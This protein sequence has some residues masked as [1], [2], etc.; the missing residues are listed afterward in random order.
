MVYFG[1]AGLGQ[2]C[3]HFWRAHFRRMTLVVEKNEATRPID[4]AFLCTYTVVTSA[5]RITK[6]VEKFM[7]FFM[8]YILV[9]CFLCH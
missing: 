2:K 9:R 6:L 5:N 8:P 7:G 4:V 3:L 1:E